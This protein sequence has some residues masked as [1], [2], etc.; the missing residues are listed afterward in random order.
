[1]TA[2]K[3][4]LRALAARVGADPGDP[5][6]E[7]ARWAVYERAVPE[8]AAWPDLL[9]LVEREPDG[10][11]ASAAVVK[12]LEEVPDGL[13]ARC[14]AALPPGGTREY[15]RVRARE[16]AIL[17]D[18]AAGAEVPG[19]GEWS[20]WLQLRAAGSARHR[21]V[22]EALAATGASRRIRHTARATLRTLP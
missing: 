18:L 17:E 9:R 20:P 2:F 19:A 13:R 7:H 1:M 11:V 10:A 16:L 5:S 6:D 15:A 14:V 8:A 4:D 21:G 22:L 12:L 3:E